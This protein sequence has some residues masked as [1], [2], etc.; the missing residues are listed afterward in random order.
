VIPYGADYELL[1]LPR[2]VRFP[3]TE[4]IPRVVKDAVLRRFGHQLGASGTKPTP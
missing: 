4:R 1:P 2:Q 3:I